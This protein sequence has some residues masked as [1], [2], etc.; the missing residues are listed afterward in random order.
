MLLSLE[1]LSTYDGSVVKLNFHD[2][3]IPC[4]EVGGDT[5]IT[6]SACPVNVF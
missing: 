5:G 2:E 4:N 1:T 6:V 3:Y